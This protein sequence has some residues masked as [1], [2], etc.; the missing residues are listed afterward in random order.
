M[1][2]R[3]YLEQFVSLPTHSGSSD[4]KSYDAVMKNICGYVR[5]YVQAILSREQEYQKMVGARDAPA[6]QQFFQHYLSKYVMS[7]H[8]M[9]SY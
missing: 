6:L 2:I 4:V 9:T 1:Q 8:M 7:K 3:S 5:D